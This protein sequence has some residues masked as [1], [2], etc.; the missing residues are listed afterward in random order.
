MTDLVERLRAALDARE[1]LIDGS[2]ILGWLTYR[3][4][5]GT[6]RY[7]TAAS[8]SGDHWIVDGCEA[9]GWASAHVVHDEDRERRE[10]AAHRKILDEHRPWS[11]RQPPACE[12]CGLDNQEYERTPDINQCPTLLALAEAYGVEA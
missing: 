2:G 7:T 12:G 5:D 3:E 1:R 8:K 4:D 11:D 6:M 9:T 10:V